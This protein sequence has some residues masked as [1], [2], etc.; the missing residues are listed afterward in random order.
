MT[1][2]ITNAIA[3]AKQ[4]WADGNGNIFSSK[5]ELIDH[6]RK[7]VVLE[8]LAAI[9][10]SNTDVAQ[11]LLANK[12]HIL[13]IFDIG[14]IKRVTK[15]EHAKLEKALAHIAEVLKDDAKALFVIENAGAIRGSFKWPTQARMKED[16]VLA[17]ATNSLLAIDGVDAALATWVLN[18]K[19]AI[20]TAYKAGLPKAVVPEAAA[21]GLARYQAEQR[22]KKAAAQAAATPVTEVQTEAPVANTADVNDEQ[23]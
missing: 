17:A 7:P 20:T 3:A 18:N 22:A 5:Q 6:V 13:D 10:G 23:F 12:E 1:N 14:G 19:E 4:V 11:F 15:A 16:E 9:G 2:A 8:A 21:A